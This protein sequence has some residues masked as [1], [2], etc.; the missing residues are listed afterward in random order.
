MLF[1]ARH[2]ATVD[3]HAY[4]DDAVARGA[5]AIA[6]TAGSASLAPDITVVRVEPS[7]AT[8]THLAARFY[9][10]PS[11]ALIGVTGTNGKTSTTYFV[12]HFLES[13]GIPT[14]II[15]TVVYEFGTRSLPAAR[16]TPDIFQLHDMLH[17]MSSAGARAIVMEISSH[18]LEQQRVGALRFDAAAFTNLTQDHLDYHHTMAA[19][20][21][22]KRLLFDLLKPPDQRATVT[23]FVIGIDDEWGARL[24]DALHARGDDVLTTSVSDAATAL[25]TAC[26][27]RVD[28]RGSS[29]ALRYSGNDCGTVR[30]P[31]LGRHNVAN[32]LTAMG[33]AHAFG[34]TMPQLCAAAATL[35]ATPGRLEFVPNNLGLT[36]VVDYAHTDD[37]L[38]NVLQCLRE[39]APRTLWVV[40]GCG[41]DRDH[42]KRPKMGAVAESLAD[43]VVVTSDNPRSE[44]PDAIIR[45]VCAGMRTTTPIAIADRREAIAYACAHAQPGDVVLIAGKGHEPYQEIKRVFHAFDDRLV[46]RDILATMENARV[47]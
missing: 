43:R 5:A 34:L 24:A 37:A 36:V 44:D 28:T 11:A 18:A 8:L 25:L 47:Q 38:R 39:I 35:P 21:D 6:I 46:A 16:T 12:R 33:I 31:L 19:Y 22:A 4:V 9:G 27:V 41:G 14:G 30:T 17:Q 26:D 23:P 32:C 13:H 20:F 1:V 15:G 42:T 40:F 3:G 10:Q 29:F 2:G 7:L 45:A